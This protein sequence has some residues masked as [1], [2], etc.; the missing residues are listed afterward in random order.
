MNGAGPIH[1]A[2]LPFA[3]VAHAVGEDERAVPALLAILKLSET[4]TRTHM[5]TRTRVHKYAKDGR[6]DGGMDGGWMDALARV[7][8]VLAAVLEHQR[9]G[10]C[11][12]RSAATQRS[13]SPPQHDFLLDILQDSR[14]AVEYR[15]VC[16]P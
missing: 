16:R 9:A 13:K 12:T 6:M 8:V 15:V 1:E 3:D 5:H 10:A 14:A 2:V 7:P 4:R 11:T